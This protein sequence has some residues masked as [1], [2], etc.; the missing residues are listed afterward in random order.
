M[1]GSDEVQFALA[2]LYKD[3]GAYDN[4][5]K[6]F[7]QLLERDPKYIEAL[8]GAGQVE[9]WSGN[10]SEALDYLNRALA[11]AIQR[12]NDEAKASVLRTLGATYG[13]MNKSSEGLRYAK[14]SLEIERRLGRLAGVADSLHSIAQMED[15]AGEP[16]ALKTYQEALELRR[17]IGDKQGVG[18]VLNDL[19]SHFAARGQNDEALVQFKAALQIQREVRN[20]VYEAAALNNIGTIYLWRGSYDD[21]QTYLQQAVAIRE[22][23]NLPS[24]AADTLHSLAEVSVKTGAYETAQGQYLKA[25]D[26]WRKVGNKRAEAI[27]LYNLG[28]VFEYQARYGAAVDSKADAVKIFKE[29]GDKGAWLPKVLASYG[30]ALGQIGQIGEAQKVLGEALPLARELKNDELI[31]RILSIQGDAFYYQGDF[32]G[33]R[34]QYQQSAAIAARA[35]LAPV[36]LVSQAESG[37]AE[38]VGGPRAT[39][40]G[41][42]R[43]AGRRRG[44][45]RPEVR[46]GL[47]FAA[48]WRLGASSEAV[49]SRARSARVNAGAG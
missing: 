3:A 36:V 45:A 28:D 30:S 4:A 18:N 12:G 44:A 7:K 31:A 21:A 24:D 40:G 22:R 27:E 9:S 33:A 23:M 37:K 25:L 1:P 5:R 39:L 16:A 43:H 14:D 38:R 15:D 48:G 42:A 49:F 34:R 8:L 19:G 29:I 17:K 46:V 41:S 47:L 20:P 11:L 26:L 6:R 10:G 2:T 32:A 35:K 13:A